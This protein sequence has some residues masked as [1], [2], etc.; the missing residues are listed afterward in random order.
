MLVFPVAHE[1]GKGG[2]IEDIRNHGI[3]P[4]PKLGEGT[5]GVTSVTMAFLA[6]FVGTAL[7]K[8]EDFANGEGVGWTGQEVA[9]VSPTAGFDKA[10]LFEAG[11]D[12]LQKFLGN[13]LAAGDLGNLDGLAGGLT[14][15]VEDRT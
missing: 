1:V 4:S 2:R 13:G 3:D 8:A 5:V 14:S 7:Q 6:V 10:G 15:E 9:S 12:Q 11:E